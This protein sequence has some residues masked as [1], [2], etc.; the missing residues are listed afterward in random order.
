[1]TRHHTPRGRRLTRAILLAPALALALAASATP[2]YAGP[3]GRKVGHVEL[4][5]GR[6]V[7]HQT[8]GCHRRTVHRSREHFRKVGSAA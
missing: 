3:G 7:G 6:K 4:Q 1:M 5:F 8:S 2:A